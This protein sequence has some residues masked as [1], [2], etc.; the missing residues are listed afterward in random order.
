[1]TINGLAAPELSE[2]W[3]LRE[4]THAES[5]AS[6]D[7]PLVVKTPD[8]E[9][10]VPR[11]SGL[12]REAVR[13]MLL[14]SVSLRNVVHDFPGYN[15]PE[16]AP[17][18]GARELRSELAQLGAV[19]VRTLALGAEPLLS[20]I[21][22]A[23]G[24]HLVPRPLPYRG[25][26][27]LVRSAAVRYEGAGAVLEAPGA[28]FRAEFHRPEAFRLLAGVGTEGVYDPAGLLALTEPALPGPAVAAALAYLTAAGLAE[29]TAARP[30]GGPRGA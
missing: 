6:P 18:E 24:A 29:V 9:L 12:L 22:Q 3:S 21:P 20:V 5:G 8:G 25:R 10:R 15:T 19:T 26:V 16:E 2:Y 28:R 27:R 1:M 4:D 14:G 30:P 13:R 23:P 11:P 7:G 17:G